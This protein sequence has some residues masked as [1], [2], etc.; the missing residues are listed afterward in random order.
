[1]VAAAH[2][3][4]A[5][6]PKPPI[7]IASAEFIRNK[8]AY[9]A[10]LRDEAPVC[11][12]RIKV[13]RAWLL[14]RYDDCTV[15]LKDPRF[16]RNRSTARGG[17]R[18]TPVPLP[19]S[20]Q[21]LAHSM[22]V[23]DEPAHHRLRSLVQK[24]FTSSALARIEP[25]IEALTH[26]LLDAIPKGRS[27]DL[28]P[29]YA[30][31]IPVTVI[32]ELVGVA[33][34]DM[35]RFKDSMRVLSDG[36]SGWSIVRTMFWDLRQTV[37]F[38]RQMIE[39]KRRHPADDVLTGLI[40]AEEAGSRLSEEELVSL[41]FLLIIAGYETTVHLIT[42]G[43]AALLEHPEQLARLRAD[44]TLMESA[45]EEILRYR[46]PVQSTKP[47]YA[48]EDVTL[49]GVTIPKG[50]TVFPLLGA[51]NHDPRAFDAPERFDVARTPNKHL[52]F[53]RGIH[54]CL[55]APLARM[56]TRIALT[57]LLERS[58]D[59]RLAVD[60]AELE[61]QTLPAWHRHKRLPVIL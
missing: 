5:I 4:G 17:G 43:V 21:L 22:I 13:L 10:W 29:A 7:D 27:V 37:R 52:G 19:K 50:A 26:E 48:T 24:A 34:A 3:L 23:E 16:V 59:L 41:V 57:A 15:M 31:P 39:V 20:V 14:S 25:R 53:G 1:M 61:Q 9:Y 42:N 2:A 6:V 30:L 60:P 44:P 40:E 12:G 35:P 11:E 33:D 51:A 32:K 8:Y 38:V 49:H 28:M 18:R 55:G 54:F 47:G 58:P 45:V 46:G 36:L 56:E